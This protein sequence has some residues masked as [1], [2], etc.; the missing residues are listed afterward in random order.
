MRTSIIVAFVLIT[1]L[2]TAQAQTIEN[3]RAMSIDQLAN[4]DV[5]SVTK[6]NQALSD[7]PAAIYVITHD[8][9]V[10]SGAQTLPEI[11][12]LAPNL[13][14]YQT[15][16]SNYIVTARGFSG[17]AADQAFA[18]KL[19][20]LIDGRSVYTPL[21][22]GVYWD[23]QDV[24]PSDI[25]RI[26]VIS[27][28]GATLWGAN[29]V[30][31]VINIITRKAAET[32][33]G[34]IDI[35]AGNLEQSVGLRYG[36][37]L[38][39]DLAYRFYV[40]DYFGDDTVTPSGANAH[41]HWSRPQGGFRLDWSPSG[42]D[43]VTLQGDDFAGSET[44]PGA[45]N[46]DIAG[47]NLTAHWT[48]NFADGSSVQFLTYYDREERLTEDGGGNFWVDTYDFE[49][50]HNFAPNGWNAV[51]WGGGVRVSDY[52]IHGP[53]SLQFVP[54]G[55]ALTLSDIFAQDSV[56]IDPSLTAI[57]GMKLEDDPYSGLTPLPSG[58]LSWKIGEDALLWA[59][60]SRAVRSPTP[61][62]EDVVEKSGA[63]V[64]LT[65]NP[66]FVDEKL[67]AYE[68]GTRIE[69]IERLSFSVSAFYNNYDD[70]RSIELAPLT[71]FPLTW[72]NKLDGHTYGFE[73]W[74]NYQLYS[75][76]RL[77]A[78]FTELREHFDFDP[79]STGM[80]VG[81]SQV[82][83]DPHETAAL[84]SAMD[85]TSDVN[86]DWD[87]RYVGRLPNPVVPAYVEMNAGV[88][89][90]VSET[91][92]LSLSGFNLLHAKHQEFPASE[93]DAVPRSFSVGLQWRF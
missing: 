13:Q 56:T 83:D 40:R 17:N 78:S 24:L 86:F 67:I 1:A 63:A 55:R 9:I 58:R 43:S 32:Q 47:R 37:T 76:W 15:S 34:L 19:L 20:V 28:P 22:S 53:P 88:G 80:A 6:S 11:L 85:L 7:A 90:N 81:V 79:T 35:S 91:L 27:G 44:N 57:F 23:M 48:H 51:N 49:V 54:E 12:R 14:V 41:D 36:G 4:L 92:R 42:S 46:N 71:F 45:P 25:D 74:G 65:G 39:D 69:P 64:L 93:A 59:A 18:N 8:Q 21:Y 61:F 50:Q 84:H 75:W 60:V 82:G 62:D 3:L 5:S 70:L 16:A 68:I 26:E 52:N 87:L 66:Y 72:G 30:N 33:G 29:A 73:S 38:G 2:S 89:W 77:S 31:G 10:R